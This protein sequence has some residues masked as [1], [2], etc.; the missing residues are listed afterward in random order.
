IY[1]PGLATP[2]GHVLRAKDELRA[3]LEARQGAPLVGRLLEGGRVRVLFAGERGAGHLDRL[4]DEIA[5]TGGYLFQP[6]IA[7]HP[8]TAAASGGRLAAVRLITLGGEGELKV[9]RAVWKPPGR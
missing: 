3:F 8:K 9:A 2:A 5:E 6:L 4:V 7:P 1:A